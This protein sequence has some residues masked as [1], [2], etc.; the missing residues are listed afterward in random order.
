VRKIISS[1]VACWMPS[2]RP[3]VSKMPYPS[4]RHAVRSRLPYAPIAARSRVNRPEAQEGIVTNN[5]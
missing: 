4:T 2:S 5:A 1:G 3:R